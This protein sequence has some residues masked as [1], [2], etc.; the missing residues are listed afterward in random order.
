M[1]AL[2]EVIFSHLKKDSAQNILTAQKIVRGDP[3][4]PKCLKGVDW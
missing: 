3:K 1:Q 2:S 4:H